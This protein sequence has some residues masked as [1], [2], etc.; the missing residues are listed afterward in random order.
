MALSQEQIMNIFETL[1]GCSPRAAD[2]A[3]LKA[4][5]PDGV[6]PDDLADYIWDHWMGEPDSPTLEQ[7]QLAITE[8]LAGKPDSQPTEVIPLSELHPAQQKTAQRHGFTVYRRSDGYFVIE[9]GDFII[10]AAETLPQA[11]RKAVA[12]LRRD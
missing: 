7:V 12:Y 6:T 5:S 4:M 2:L 9:H 10:S 3:V 1:L 11:L 8:V